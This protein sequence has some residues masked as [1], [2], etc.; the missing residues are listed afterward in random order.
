MMPPFYIHNAV[1]T[2]EL[3]KTAK[4]SWNMIVSDK[5]PEFKR[6]KEAGICEHT[7]SL[8]K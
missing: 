5:S 3:V 4:E 1:A 2:P 8:G 7:S 6:Q